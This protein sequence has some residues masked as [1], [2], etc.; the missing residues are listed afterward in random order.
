MKRARGR[1]A[2][3]ITIGSAAFLIGFAFACRHAGDPASPAAG[4]DPIFCDVP[5]SD[6]AHPAAVVELTV[7]SGG[8]EM[9]GFAY[10]PA[11]AGPHPVVILLHGYPGTER[12][13][14]LAHALRR[15]GFTVLFFHYRGAWGSPGGFS[16]A[17]AIEDATAAID[18]V[19]TDAFAKKA[20]ADGRRIALVGHSMGGFVAVQA[21]AKN[22]EVRCV[23]S[24]AGA[25][26]GSLGGL[27]QD[28]AVRAGVAAR[29]DSWSGSIVLAP[30][31]SLSTELFEHA[32]EFD[33][34]RLAEPLADRD[35]LLV[36]G[37]RDEVTP[38]ALHHEPLREAFARK[39][40]EGARLD[41]VMLDADHAFSSQRVALT[42]EVVG[43][44]GTNCRSAA[45]EED[46]AWPR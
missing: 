8:A 29:F 39:R 18:F 16:F 28:P 12:H 40:S 10:L 7:P 14:D 4:C 44:L 1:T 43:W 13:G 35:V 34:L 45:T 33:L 37:R 15:A 23:V 32:K 11:G 24:L 2:R 3:A 17:H 19:Q 9:N 20:R 22:A 25:N 30:G 21:G 26:M 38:P 31:H 5:D 6:P 41:A 36:A 46:R 42:R 27:M